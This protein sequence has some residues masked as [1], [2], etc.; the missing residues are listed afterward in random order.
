MEFLN[1]FKVPKHAAWPIVFV[2]G[3]VLFGPKPL[4][5]GLG[6]DLFIDHYRIWIGVA[7]LFFLATGLMP[8]FPWLQSK[9]ANKLAEQSIRKE[10]I[11]L[12]AELTPEEK[13][14]LRGYIKKNTKARDLD[15]QNGVVS[16]LLAIN[17]LTLAFQVSYGG[18]RGSFTFPV[19]MQDWLWKELNENPKYLS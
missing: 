11:R 3:L 1:W 10:R 8:L 7:F 16:R 4:K 6:L 9:I 5:V 17:F 15:I 14:I 2:T 18:N 12:L 19:N 13:Y